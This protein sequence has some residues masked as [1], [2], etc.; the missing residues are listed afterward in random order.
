[1]IPR[2][3]LRGIRPMIAGALNDLTHQVGEAVHVASV[4]W[5]LGSPAARDFLAQLPEDQVYCSLRDETRRRVP[6]GDSCDEPFHT[7]APCIVYDEG[8]FAEADLA[9]DEV[10]RV[11]RQETGENQRD[12]IA[13]ERQRWLGMVDLIQEAL[14]LL[15]CDRETGGVGRGR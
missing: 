4:Q 6:V 3:L 12:V 2:Q 10:R 9:V 14:N 1:M 11:D 8:A 13:R 5:D 7:V 15:A